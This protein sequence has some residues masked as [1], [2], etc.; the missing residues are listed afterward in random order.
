[1]K[2]RIVSLS[3]VFV[4][5]F[6]LLP[7]Q[8]SALAAD[9]TPQAD[10]LNT[11]GLFLGT[12]SGYNLARD[13]TR[14]EA[15]TMV[16][17]LLGREAE[18]RENQYEHPF[19]DVPAW[20]DD[21]IGY[22]FHFDITKGISATRYGSNNKISPAQYATFMLRSLS[23]DD[24]AGDFTW[25]KALDKMSALGILSSANAT[26]FGKTA[27]LPRGTAVAISHASLLANSK[28]SDY[29]LLLRLY[30]IEHAF[31]FTQLKKA[32]QKDAA[33]AK[34]AVMHGMPHINAGRGTVLNSEAIY[35]KCSPAVFYIEVFDSDE[36]AYGSGSG[37]FISANGIAVTNY[38]VLEDAV[39]AKITTNNGKIYNVDR[40]LAYSEDLD[41]AILKIKGTD[42][43][44]LQIG[45]PSQLRVAQRIYCMGS[46]LGFSDTISEGLVSSPMK[47][48]ADIDRELIQFSAPISSG[49]SGGA[50]INE[51]GEVVGISTYSYYYG[52]NLN[53]AIPVT[54]ISKLTYLDP[55]R[56]L[57]SISNEAYWAQCFSDDPDEQ[58]TEEELGD[59]PML[60]NWGEYLCTIEN[61]DDVS[62]FGIEALNS[63]EVL[64]VLRTKDIAHREHLRVDIID[65]KTDEVVIRSRP[66]EETPYLYLSGY[67]KKGGKYALRVMTDGSP[68]VVWKN[69]PYE[70]VSFIEDVPT[71]Y[72]FPYEHTSDETEPNDTLETA[73]HLMFGGTVFG[74]LSK[75][76]DVDCFKF[77]VDE[78]ISTSIII[79]SYYY[80]ADPVKAELFDGKGNRIAALKF[81]GG[82]T[83]PNTRSL[84]P[85][86]YYIV[87][88]SDENVGVIDEDYPPEYLLYVGNLDPE[89]FEW[90]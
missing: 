23:Y 14:A 52:Q 28:D 13:M 79:G 59:D 74:L 46:P 49:S 48:Y 22:L 85:G 47:N 58:I 75:D 6:T 82:L 77:T 70:F 19:D 39:F 9:Y 89:F 41:L 71:G 87:I 72:T 83:N 65:L 88:Q 50:L 54:D 33:V 8:T 27:T 30:A 15:G 81:S 32:A 35:K 2:K 16:V 29:S 67:L 1:M 64:L 24:E 5:L 36:F 51:Y 3:I 40:V 25:S 90:F 53:F 44:T 18:A 7:L 84:L 31:T 63:K 4:L 61:A 66:V 38:H 73:Q 62:L 80:Y 86:D 56:S 17:R 10:T 45:D 42:F 68:D 69:T 60:E 34:Q 76:K 26:A 20:A 21:Y 12:P 78:K 37:F 55:P 11:L 43:P 57:L